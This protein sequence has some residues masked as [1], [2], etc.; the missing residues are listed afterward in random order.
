MTLI[1]N[2]GFVDFFPGAETLNY[3]AAVMPADIPSHAHF[4]GE[5]GDYLSIPFGGALGIAG[6]QC[7]VM[8][9]RSTSLAAASTVVSRW[10]N[11]GN[12][13]SWRVERAA[14]GNFVYFRSP[15]GATNPSV[16]S[17]VPAWGVNK[18]KWLAVCWLEDDGLGNNVTYWW[19]SDT[20]LAGSWVVGSLGA[21]DVVAGAGP[22]TFVGDAGINI[23]GHTLGTL[24]P[25]TGDVSHLQI[26]DGIGVGGVPGGSRVFNMDLTQDLIGVDPNATSF[27]ATSGHTVTINRSGSPATSLV[28]GGYPPDPSLMW[29]VRA[30]RPS[31]P[32]A[33]F[34]RPM[35]LPFYLTFATTGV[36]AQLYH[37]D[38]SVT[39]MFVS[40][41]TLEAAG[42]PAVGQMV[43]LQGRWDRDLDTLYL[44]WRK[45]LGHDL[46]GQASWVTAGSTVAAGK[47]ANQYPYVYLNGITAGSDM[48]LGPAYRWNVFADGQLVLDV[49]ID[50][51]IDDPAVVGSFEASTGQTVVVARAGAD[52]PDYEFVSGNWTSIRDE[53]VIPKPQLWSLDLCRD[54][55][56]IA[57]CDGYLFNGIRRR[58]DQGDFVLRTS[59]EGVYGGHYVSPHSGLDGPF[60][61]RDVNTVRLVVDGRIVYPG[62]ISP[63]QGLK[64]V[65]SEQGE[66]WEWTGFDPWWYFDGRLVLPDPAI[67]LPG[68]WAVGTD[69]RSGVAS[70]V[71]AA[72]INANA[73]AGALAARQMPGLTIEDQ[74]VGTTLDFSARLETLRELTKRLATEGEFEAFVDIN[75]DGNIEVLLAEGRD[76]SEGLVLSDQHDLTQSTAAFQPPKA[77]V[78]L[79]GGSG[80][81]ATRLF[82]AYGNGAIG[83]ARREQFSDQSS[84]D[85]ASEVLADA[86]LQTR[87]AVE[88]Y[89]IGTTLTDE[90]AKLAIAFGLR[91][92][93]KLSI[94]IKGRTYSVPIESYSFDVSPDRQSMR[95]VFGVAIPDAL[96]RLKRNVARTQDRLQRSVT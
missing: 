65:Q 8:R 32:A 1:Y 6:S 10:N 12:K 7:V 57:S 89:A 41:A 4:P 3:L 48:W 28:F 52:P 26:Y 17:S 59:P 91:L 92:G 22:T 74:I 14:A 83:L 60:D 77:S 67:D 54:W 16:S 49:N 87:L 42:F 69:V 71:L 9:V 96:S 86:A 79:T 23:S 30:I 84:L 73:G 39:N 53:P 31:N 21:P 27:Q 93:D 44:E 85:Q 13:R 40:Y 64:I 61:P 43:D 33:N 63:E 5:T 56:R 46:T 37:D 29:R 18:W 11:T 80:E 20:G 68:P 70:T 76:L 34:Y 62:V 78:T 82:R 66:I 51:D 75:F 50:K 15:D 95:P 25:F 24:V 36:Y 88:S 94:I 72:Y 55:K 35:N 19:E 38:L 47:E 81:L 58:N 45:P 2:P 90:Q